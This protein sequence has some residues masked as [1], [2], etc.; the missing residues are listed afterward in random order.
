MAFHDMT[1]QEMSKA[2]QVSQSQLSKILRG[3][4]S[5]DLEAFEA[6]CEAIDE[7][8]SSLI[9]E[10]E[11]IAARIRQA[12]P[13]TFVHASKIRYVRDGV[14]LSVSQSA[15]E[16]ES[17]QSDHLDDRDGE[18]EQA[19]IEATLAQL[20]TD[21]LSLAASHDPN[22]WREAQGDAYAG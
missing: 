20:K 22:K 2:I 11:S 4:R 18:E 9:K 16:S 7:D 15:A 1:Q 13:E 3:E 10:G 17:S 8:A 5:I 21:P 19:K 14:K 12:S 6:F